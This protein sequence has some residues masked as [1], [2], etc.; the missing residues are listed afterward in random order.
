M[1]YRDRLWLASAMVVLG[2]SVT[3]GEAVEEDE[4]LASA[5]DLLEQ[6]VFAEHAEPHD[7]LEALGAIASRVG[8]AADARGLLPLYRLALR[9]S[10]IADE[11]VAL[12]VAEGFALCLVRTRRPFAAVRDALRREHEGRADTPVGAG[13]AAVADRFDRLC[14]GRGV[15]RRPAP[16]TPVAPARAAR[17]GRR[18]VLAPGSAARAAPSAPI[19][20]PRASAARAG[21]AAP[22]A[23]AGAAARGAPPTAAARPGQAARPLLPAAPPAGAMAARGAVGALETTRMKAP[24]GAAIALIETFA[25]G[26]DPARVGTPAASAAR[27]ARGPLLDPRRVAA[28]SEGRGPLAGGRP[29]LPKAGPLMRTAGAARAAVTPAAGAAA[30]GAV[31]VRPR[32]L[33]TPAG[34]ADADL[35]AAIDKAAAAALGALVKELSDEADW[36]VR[37]GDH[38]TALDILGQ[39]VHEA[40]DTEFSQQALT[41]AFALVLAHRKAEARDKLYAWFETWASDRG[42]K[43]ER[44]AARLLVL[45]QRYRDGS[46]EAARDGLRAF[47][48]DHGDTRL[49]PQAKLLLALATWRAGDR[50]EAVGQLDALVRSAP[51]HESAPR[52][53][54]LV[55]YLHFAAGKQEEAQAAFLRVIADYPDS[56][57]AEKAVEFLGAEAAKRAEAAAE[58]RARLRARQLP[59]A[60]CRRA[61]TP[62]RIDGRLDEAAWTH[63]PVVRLSHKGQGDG[64]APEP[65]PHVAVRLLWDDHSLYVAFECTDD[66]IRSQA[67]T[68]DAPVLLWDSVRVLIAPPAPEREP[69][70]EAQPEPERGAAATTYFDIAVSPTGAL[71]DGKVAMARGVALWESVRQASAWNGAGLQQAVVVDGSPNDP[72][73]DRGWVAELAVP[74]AA[75]ATP[76]AAGQ[77]W[78]VNLVW[79]NRQ[80]KGDRV[81]TSWAP[82]GSWLPQPQAF[83]RLTLSAGEPQGD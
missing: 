59:S 22:A 9:S 56:A 15:A 50:D 30:K 53:Q 44:A 39:V 19:L 36:M 23:T 45:P 13:L 29:A 75:L 49:G 69:E 12:A 83:G 38:E 16:A 82:L 26:P 8:S 3:A 66:D 77:R 20:E 46:F 60:K 58:E 47:V 37:H 28:R 6:Y 65:D 4:K 78:R 34:R 32:A 68:R 63:A 52:A 79:V 48:A 51:G 35:R 1:A 81:G 2:V 62:P 41:R 54:F 76:P 57:F 7:Q 18:A 70:A 31:A 64:P 24:A 73:P 43:A 71:C 21:P 5:R 67:T 80:A 33:P 72:R 11:D 74:F 10:R 25:V 42:G 40:A 17:P 27:V 14:E 55:G 61:P